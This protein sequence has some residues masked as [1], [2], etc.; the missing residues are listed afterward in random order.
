MKR[1]ALVTAFLMGC[2]ATG[3]PEETVTKAE[4]D[5]WMTELSNWGRW[6]DDDQRGTVNLI[7]PETRKAA[8]RLV[9]EGIS[10]SLARVAEKETAVDN[11][12]PFGHRMT[13]TGA[14][15]AAGQ[16]VG[17]EYTV[18]YHGY[19]HSHMD[20]LAHMSFEGKSYNGFAVAKVTE[21][22]T[23][24]LAV[25]NYQEGLFARAVLMD[26]PRL[27]GVEYLEPGTAILPSDLEAWEE[28]AGVKVGS[29]DVVL[30]YTGRWK[31]R[32]ENGPFNA[33]QKSAGLYASCAQWLR[34]RD[35]AVLGS[36]AASDVMP[37]G[38]D[39]VRQPIHQLTLVAMGTP[40]LDNLDLEAVARE[41]SKQERWE[42]LL[43]A[44][45]LAVGG[46]TG[47]PLNPIA[48]F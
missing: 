24:H 16:F 27:K 11:P 6:G 14:A 28:K 22:G 25:T 31:L 38:V 8:A 41:A 42:F 33:G 46:G 20:S 4:V 12:S 44:G 18:Q 21:A 3:G 29:G 23:P 26:I 34:E 48:T 1:F 7:T 37:S 5:A 15:P 19:A 36:D 13:A 2:T 10:V 9:T 47:S 45:P 30:I 40:I 32:D 35:V 39:G 17:D 43:T